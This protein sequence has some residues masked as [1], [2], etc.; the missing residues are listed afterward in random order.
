MAKKPKG[1]TPEELIKLIARIKAL[2]DIGPA[3]IPTGTAIIDHKA[4]FREAM[5]KGH[6]LETLVDMW[7]EHGR[8]IKPDTFAGNLRKSKGKTN[9]GKKRA[10]VKEKGASQKKPEPHVEESKDADKV[11]EAPVTQKDQDAE[12]ASSEKEITLEQNAVQTSEPD[13]LTIPIE[14]DDSDD[15]QF[16]DMIAQYDAEKAAGFDGGER[17]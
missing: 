2:P 4:E 13:K 10:P 6:S 7:N 5:A 15:G 16:D 12:R 1:I 11:D 9:A 14:A 8:P 3:F 17:G